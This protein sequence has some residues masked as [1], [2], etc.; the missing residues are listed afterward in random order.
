MSGDHW[1]AGD[2]AKWMDHGKIMMH[3]KS[4]QLI[5]GEHPHSIQNN[6]HYALID[7][8]PVEFDGHRTLISIRLEA[9]NYLKQSELSGDEIRSGGSGTIQADGVQVFEFFFRDVQWALLKAHSLIGQLSEH[10]SGWLIKSEREK[11]IGRPIFYRERDAIIENLIVDEGCLMVRR[12]DGA[13]FPEPI[14]STP[15]DHCAP[16][17]LVKVEVLDPNIWWFRKST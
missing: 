2:P 8:K 11:L 6:L 9:L 5:Y 12:E 1:G 4:Y 14:Y 10:S 17:T 7:G 13:P 16:E 3:G 15:D